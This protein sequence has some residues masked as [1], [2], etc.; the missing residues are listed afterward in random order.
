LGLILGG[1]T[2]QR[3]QKYGNKLCAMGL[4]SCEVCCGLSA[5]AGGLGTTAEFAGEMAVGVGA[6]V[7]AVGGAVT[8]VVGVGAG[9]AAV[10][11]VVDAHVSLVDG[12][13]SVDSDYND[14][15]EKCKKKKCEKK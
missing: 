3:V 8:V 11:T 5:T 14:C 6:G 7:V 4:M 13:K 9:A 15:M 10:A 2:L 12:L 1:S